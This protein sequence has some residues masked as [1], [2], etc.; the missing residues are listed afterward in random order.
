MIAISSLCHI[1]YIFILKQFDVYQY[2]RG[3]FIVIVKCPTAAGPAD[4]LRPEHLEVCSSCVCVC[5]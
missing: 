2:F 4:W 1:S 3:Q 5:H